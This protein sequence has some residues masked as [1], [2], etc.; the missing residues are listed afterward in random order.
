MQDRHAIESKMSPAWDRLHEE[1]KEALANYASS[2]ESMND[3]A[4]VNAFNAEPLTLPDISKIIGPYLRARAD[5]LEDDTSRQWVVD[6]YDRVVNDT[7]QKLANLFEGDLGRLAEMKK[8]FVESV[9]DKL[10]SYIPLFTDKVAQYVAKKLSTLS[11]DDS[12]RPRWSVDQFITPKRF[13]LQ[14]DQYDAYADHS[15]IWFIDERGYILQWDLDE[16]LLRR[17]WPECELLFAAYDLYVAGPG[18]LGL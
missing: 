10:A 17:M 6:R 8:R 11:T 3:K 14:F 2:S 13:L 9:G 15:G 7:A 1:T 5:Y 12:P 4:L 18:K 16:C